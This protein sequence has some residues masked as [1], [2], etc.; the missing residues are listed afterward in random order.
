VRSYKRPRRALLF[1][2]IGGCGM[3]SRRRRRCDTNVSASEALDNHRWLMPCTTSLASSALLL[4]RLLQVLLV[5]LASTVEVH[6]GRWHWESASP[7]A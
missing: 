7:T 6:R 5:A 3:P 2:S 4:L 1:G